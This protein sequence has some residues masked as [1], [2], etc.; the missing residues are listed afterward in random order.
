M[1][2]FDL[3][4]TFLRALGTK[5]GNSSAAYDPNAFHQPSAISVADDGSLWV[6]EG[7]KNETGRLGF[8]RRIAVWNANGQFS[9]HFIGGTWYGANQICLHEQDPALAYAYGVVYKVEPGQK[10]AYKPLRYASSRREPKSPFQLWTGS[11]GV[12]FGS[13]RMF[14][15]S[16]SG[17]NREYLLQANGY[18]ILYQA[19]A[20]GDYRPVLAIGS[21][22]HNPAFPEV[23]EEKRAVFIW[24]DL[25]AD[26]QPQANEFVRV[27]SG[28]TSVSFFSGW[29]YPPPLDFVW[30][31]GGWEFK[32]SRFTDNGVPVYD[33]A[34]AL[35][36]ASPHHSLRVGQ[37]LISTVAGKNGSPEAGWYFAGNLHFTDL[38][39]R[40]TAHY[41]FN[42]PAVHASW[43][44]TL[45]K[46]G[47]TGRSIGENFF[48]GIADSAGE[49]GQ[50]IATHGNKGQAFV[51][52][53]DGLFVTTLFSDP[54]EGPKGQGSTE[55]RG[56]DWTKV[57]MNEEAF[58][59]W[60]GRQADGNLRYLFGHTAAHVVQV[61]GLD[62]V[63]RFDAGLVSIST[64]ATATLSLDNAKPTQGAA[65]S[66]RVP[67]VRGAYPP[68]KAD[69]EMHEWSDIPRQEIKLGDDLVARVALAHDL[70]HLWILAEV[71]DPSPALNS[72]REPNF[73]FKTGDAIELQFGPAR[74]ARTRP[75]EGDIRIILA[76]SAKKPVAMKLL[77]V[78]KNAKPAEGFIFESP[79][80]KVPFASVSP[81]NNVEAKFVKTATGYICEAKLNCDAI[82]LS[83]AASG[84][85]LRGDIGVLFSNEGGESTQARAYLFD[86]SPGATITADVPSEAELHP[87]QWG[88]WLLE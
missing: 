48:S 11:P 64:P 87:A 61:H 79:V 21:H 80:H 76:P 26:E 4:R 23:K 39:G 35:K 86:H 37:H 12:L 58:G 20:T 70:D 75:V 72:A 56:A 34:H 19:D 81:L 27:E 53:E 42:W 49:I 73:L 10:P 67:N 88:E 17:Q 51:F 33:K 6:A 52:S 65:A 25:N 36:L 40:R 78:K 44:S 77:P 5:G 55:K 71:T 83:H 47:Q 13:T 8:A 15:S 43:S 85:R 18:P 32:P 66:L 3:N 9:R 63:K 24:T 38:A 16:V 84:L 82:A 30:R 60:F 57:T 2:I 50:V 22:Q 29:G 31:L 62:K 1:K 41:R 28:S 46:P 74:P 59:G 7:N 54:R 45:Y 68:F 69:G 14:R